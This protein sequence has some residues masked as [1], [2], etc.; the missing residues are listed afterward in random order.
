MTLQLR[1]TSVKFDR[2]LNITAIF[3][4]SKK[5]KATPWREERLWNTFNKQ[6]NLD[7]ELAEFEYEKDRNYAVEY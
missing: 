7:E 5:V 3:Y 1:N 6:F 2:E 4:G